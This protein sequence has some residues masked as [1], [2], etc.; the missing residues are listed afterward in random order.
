MA[1]NKWVSR[2]FAPLQVELFHPTYN[3][4]APILLEFQVLKQ[5]IHHNSL[6]GGGFTYFF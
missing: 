5:T 2:V 4:L 1:E 6:L 3:W